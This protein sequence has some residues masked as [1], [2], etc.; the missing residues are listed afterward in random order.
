MGK[1][2]G[3]YRDRKELTCMIFTWQMK[4]NRHAPLERGR[5]L[6]KKADFNL[7]IEQGDLN[8]P[9]SGVKRVTGRKTRETKTLNLPER[10]LD[11]HKKADGRSSHSTRIGEVRTDQKKRSSGGDRP[12]MDLCDH[13]GKGGEPVDGINPLL[14]RNTGFFCTR[15]VLK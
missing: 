15:G 8:N 13:Q 5:R 7:R 4:E 11:Q 1:K 2:G 9:L 6:S 3:T 14:L 10:N 12:G